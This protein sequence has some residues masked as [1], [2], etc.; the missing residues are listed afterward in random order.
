MSDPLINTAVDQLS[1]DVQPNHIALEE[2][3]RVVEEE[4]I[5]SLSPRVDIDHLEV[6]L[7]IAS[8]LRRPPYSKYSTFTNQGQSLGN[9]LH[10]EWPHSVV[11]C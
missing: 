3:Q 6:P 5:E 2:R 4:P 8:L 9:K 7:E 1:N 10:F 11:S